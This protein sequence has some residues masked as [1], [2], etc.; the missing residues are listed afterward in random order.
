MVAIRAPHTAGP[1]GSLRDELLK[2]LA[3][4]RVRGIA[5]I[6]ESSALITSGLLDSV[7][8]FNLSLWVE[9]R[10]GRPL[11]PTGFDLANEWNT[12][13][14]VV[15]F[16]ERQRSG[17]TTGAAQAPHWIGR[18]HAPLAPGYDL[19]RY[20]PAFKEAV[21]RLQNRLWSSSETL[22]RRFFEWRYEQ[23]P[24]LSE[25]LIYLALKEGKPVATRGFGQAV[26]EAGMGLPPA[27]W[28]FADDLVVL[29]EHENQGL[30]AAFSERARHDLAGRGVRFF[31]SLSALRVT[32]LQ[33]LAEGARSVGA[34]HPV[35]FRPWP[36]LALDRA[37]DLSE[38][39]P[40][41]W[42]LARWRSPRESAV[43]TYARLDR[44]R[45][46]KSGG[47]II[48]SS[49][50]VRPQD[51]A[52]LIADLPYDGRIRQLR[53]E[54]Y[55][56]WRYRNP[57]HEY[58]FIYAE[59]THGIEGYAV[60]GRGLS[61]LANRRRINI[62]DCEARTPEAYSGLLRFVIHHGSPTDL[63][64][65][66]A[67]L[68][69]DRLESLRSCGFAAVDQE[70]TSRGLPSVLVWPVGDEGDIRFGERSLLDLESW[71]LRMAYTSHT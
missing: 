48:T 52:R 13:A 26:W 59:S 44:T 68:G 38:T 64:T 39:K 54:P 29:P 43:R 69:S 70:Q 19:V 31:L 66:T 61:D 42:R 16:V 23:C 21:V 56:A 49:A 14:S 71:D 53:D 55:F 51:M 3:E 18:S 1:S 58:R 57:L 50:T 45:A 67:T 62:A 24:Q 10:I 36:I 46:D 5:S 6:D 15:A 30:F 11:D 47:L 60:L 12:V 28:Y 41:L 17:D 4:W 34:M 40:L 25:P 27:Q 22:N 63:V 7:A 9:E 33:S 2:A 65:W 8:L 32:R 37:R 35:G 20:T